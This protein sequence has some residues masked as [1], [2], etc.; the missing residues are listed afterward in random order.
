MAVSGSRPTGGISPYDARP[1]AGR[2]RPGRPH[3][4][5][6]SVR[7]GAA[8][9]ASLVALAAIWMGAPGVVRAVGAELAAAVGGKRAT[10]VA[11]RPAGPPPSLPLW[12]DPAS[13]AAR[14]AA[15]IAAS[16]PGDAAILRWLAAKPQASW[17]GPWLGGPD[18]VRR[19]AAR[20]VGG[21]WAARSLPTLVLYA[22]PRRSCRRDPRDRQLARDY[23]AT[24]R[25]LALAIAAR[26]ALVI[27][28]PDA[29]AEWG[30]LDARSRDQRQ[31]LLR[32]AL[33]KLASLPRARVY[34]DAGHPR[35]QPAR[36]VASRLARVWVPRLRGVALNVANFQ[37]TG[38]VVR[39]GRA[40]LQLVAKA[41]GV[42]ECRRAPARRCW[43]WVRDR[44][45]MVVDTSRNGIPEPPRRAT[46]NPAGVAVGE[47]PRL[48]PAGSAGVDALLWVK[49]PGV[50]DGP[51]RGGPP[52]GV[53]WIDYALEIVRRSPWFSPGGGEVTAASP[54][55]ASPPAAD[56]S[57]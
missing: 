55:T 25:A 50:S 19:H 12:V 18:G 24:V 10:A 3:G 4:R 33:A 49:G 32:Y 47:P 1:G 46:C 45:G 51:C 6:R 20:V 53:F 17:V 38:A 43:R 35:W 52:G 14:A 56:A 13:L 26:P 54:P 11:L 30:C 22:L 28:E 42:R 2:A 7:V 21:A 8:L 15:K 9:A 27:V 37:P 31:A 23:R 16:R 5:G 39:Y 48:R 41:H 40:V 44:L 34:V 57:G 36:V 29:V